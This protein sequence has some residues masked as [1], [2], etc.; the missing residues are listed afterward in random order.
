MVGGSM[1]GVISF[2]RLGKDLLCKLVVEMSP[3]IG[4]DKNFQ[5]FLVGKPEEIIILF[6]TVEPGLRNRAAEDLVSF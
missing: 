1:S 4:F 6:N 5:Q 2:P 3:F